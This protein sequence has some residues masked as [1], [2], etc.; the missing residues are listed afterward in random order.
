MLF[1]VE[2]IQELLKTHL[3]V[4]RLKKF[5]KD[6]NDYD[7]I[8]ESLGTNSGATHPIYNKYLWFE[9]NVIIN[10]DFAYRS[11]VNTNPLSAHKYVKGDDRYLVVF[12]DDYVVVVSE[13]YVVSKITKEELEHKYI[14]SWV[15]SIR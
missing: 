14:K 4:K 15:T 10:V 6:S 8:K 3:T 5:I 13:H 12:R 1:K 7:D 2:K 11:R 9:D